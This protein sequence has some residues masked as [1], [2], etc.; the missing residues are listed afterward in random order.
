[1]PSPLYH[2]IARSVMEKRGCEMEKEL[3]IGKTYRHHRPCDKCSAVKHCIAFYT[4]DSRFPYSFLCEE[5]LREVKEEMWR[6]GSA[7]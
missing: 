1:M 2:N 5:C 4:S 6:G 7:R 3:W